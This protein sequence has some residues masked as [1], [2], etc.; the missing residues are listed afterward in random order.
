MCVCANSSITRVVRCS[1][2]FQKNLAMES[3]EVFLHQ[4]LSER[5]SIEC[6]GARNCQCKTLLIQKIAGI[7]SLS[8][9][10]WGIYKKLRATIA[11]LVSPSTRHS[12][13]PTHNQHPHAV[14]VRPLL[15]ILGASASPPLYRFPIHYWVWDLGV[16][17]IRSL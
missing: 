2:V 13:H 5:K 3:E 11:K 4:N 12:K 17:L 10:K 8:L 9:I 1:L 15:L 16:F 7:S 14:L 6:R